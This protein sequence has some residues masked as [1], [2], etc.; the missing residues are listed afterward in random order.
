MLH[1]V[2]VETDH[3]TCAEYCASQ[4]LVCRHAQ[5]NF[6]SGCVLNHGNHE[7]Q[8]MSENGCLQQWGGQVCGCGPADEHQV[9]VASCLGM[10]N[11]T[12]CKRLFSLGCVAH[13]DDCVQDPDSYDAVCSDAMEWHESIDMR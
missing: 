11:T 13:T 12:A 1:T 8:D 5:D 4:G 2:A 7:H 3:S 6:N 9:Q 10:V